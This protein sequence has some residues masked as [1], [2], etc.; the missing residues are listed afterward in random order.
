MSIIFSYQ[1]PLND[2][3]LGLLEGYSDRLEINTHYISGDF[4]TAKEMDVFFPT[5]TVLDGRKR[6]YS[7][8]GRAFLELAA[9]GEYP[10]KR[11][12]LPEISE[13]EAENIT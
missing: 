2:G 10:M 8:F 13:T 7:P 12:Y 6:Y 5:L 11:P 3:M 9:A 1:C 4:Q